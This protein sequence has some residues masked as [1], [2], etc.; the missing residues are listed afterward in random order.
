VEIK[1]IIQA[2]LLADHVYFDAESGKCII[3]GSYN[4]FCVRTV[5]GIHNKPSVMYLCL[6]EV[7]GKTDITL[8][9]VDLSNNKVL[10]EYGP[11]AVES[12][13][14]MEVLEMTVQVPEIP[15][16][17]YGTYAFEVH[18]WNELLGFL[19]VSVEPFPENTGGAQ[20]KEHD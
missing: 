19:R 20:K 3:A 7:R 13:D 1:P 18:A 16:P 2:L 6:T 14:P 11:L 17:R 4:G 9:Y 12:D 8:R 10:L 15:I 5:P